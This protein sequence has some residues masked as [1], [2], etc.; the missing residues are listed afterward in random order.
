MAPLPKRVT[1][2]PIQIEEELA[3]AVS[4]KLFSPLIKIELLTSPLINAD[5]V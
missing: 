5:V 4:S 1:L 3:L 2:A